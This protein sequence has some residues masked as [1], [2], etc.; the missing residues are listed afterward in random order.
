MEENGRLRR[1]RERAS[2]RDHTGREDQRRASTGPIRPPMA[3]GDVEER[4]FAGSPIRSGSAGSSRKPRHLSGDGRGRERGEVA[5]GRRGNG[6]GHRG[7]PRPASGTGTGAGTGTGR[8]GRRWPR[9]VLIGANVFT[10]VCLL[11]SAAVFGYVEYRTGQLKVGPHAPHLAPDA[12]PTA[13][14]SSG[15]LPPMNILLI[16][17]NTRTGLNPAQKQFGTA[18]QVGGARS[19]VTMVL[20]LDPAA[21]TASLLSIPR[22]VFVRLPP[23]SLSG[24]YAKIDGALNGTKTGGLKSGPDNLINAIT[25]DFGIPINHYISINFDGFQQTIHDIGGIKMNFPMPLRDPYSLLNIP[26]PGC[27]RLGGFQALALV[28]ARH[29][30]YFSNGSWHNDPLSDLSR[31]VRDHTFLRVFV[32]TARAEMTNPLKANALIGGLLHQVTVDPGLTPSMLLKIFKVYRHVNPSTIPETTMP[33]TTVLSYHYGGANYGD[34]DMPV[35]PLDHQVI[36]N[37]TTTSP[38]PRSSPSSIRVSVVN[39]SGKYRQA[40]T[41]GQG[42]AAR[43]FQFV[44]ASN[45]PIPAAVTE[46]SVLYHPG[47]SAQGLSVLHA[48]QGAVILRADSAVPSGSV[49]VDAGSVL[50][51]GPPAAPASP[52]TTATGSTTSKS[53]SRPTAAPRTT[54]TTALTA[55]GQPPSAAKDHL[56][57]FD[58]TPCAGG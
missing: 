40:T 24:H 4:P 34:V 12:T 50:A 2:S 39:I 29:L 23:H 55:G 32:S 37:W 21:H 35:E 31:I 26:H 20:H 22:D 46:T 58:P 48:L 15:G 27:Q 43:G 17:N 33:I 9:R 13:A 28:R 49:V 10:A 51:V 25:S 7:G 56:T 30:Q 57:P 52:A 54:T 36:D 53:S 42:L 11:S 14:G 6:S 38:L 3:A 5:A 16:G 8:L 44:S 19:D 45:G 47:D 1:P 18:A 41:I